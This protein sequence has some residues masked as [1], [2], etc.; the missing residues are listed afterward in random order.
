M[1]EAMYDLV[2][3]TRELVNICLM[4]IAILCCYKYLKD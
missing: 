2:Y 1:T 4:L 3:V